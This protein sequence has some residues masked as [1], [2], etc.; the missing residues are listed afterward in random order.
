MPQLSSDSSFLLSVDTLRV[1]ARIVATRDPFVLAIQLHWMPDRIDT[2]QVKTGLPPRRV[3][4]WMR[5]TD[6]V[7]WTV[8]TLSSERVAASIRKFMDCLKAV[9]WLWHRPARGRR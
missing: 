1:E 6:D 3:I 9:D 8:R 7:S 5:W 4:G 2:G